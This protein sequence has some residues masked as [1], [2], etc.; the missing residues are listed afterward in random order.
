MREAERYGDTAALCLSHRALGTT[1]VTMG[2]FVAGRQH[3]ERARALYD[4]MSMRA[5]AIN[6]GRTSVRLRYATCW[7]LWHLGYFDQASEVAA[8]AVRHADEV[9]STYAWSIR[10]ATPA[11]CS[12]YSAAGLRRRH[13][14]RDGS[15]RSAT[16][17]A[18]RSGLRVDAS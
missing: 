18:F 7:A 12:T 4:P 1:Y 2:E 14:M 10:S 13:L 16:S 5:S 11:G 15:F 17:M 8:Q 3:L 6:M 9:A